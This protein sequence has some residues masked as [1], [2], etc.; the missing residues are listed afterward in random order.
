VKKYSIKEKLKN[1]DRHYHHPS[2][3][4]ERKMLKA[5]QLGSLTEALEDFTKIATLEKPSLANESLRSIKNSLIASCTLFTRAII[6]AGIDPEDAYTISDVFIN[7]IED[8]STEATL[9][10]FEY[11]ML[12]EFVYLV[13]KHRSDYYPHPISKV[14]KFIYKNTTEKL[15]VAYLAHTFN[16]SPDYLSRLFYKEVGTHLVDYI[17]NQKIELAKNYLEFSLM[18]IT[19]IAMLLNFCDPAY[20]TNVFKKHTGLSPSCYRKNVHLSF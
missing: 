17:Q 4:H 9:I 3:L 5:I 6:E 12:K 18:P 1:I 14:I 15:S 13:Q 7:Q 2:Y 20:F 8:L 16:L 19:D 10:S 11:D